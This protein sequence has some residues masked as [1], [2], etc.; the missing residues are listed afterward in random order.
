[1]SCFFT[2]ILSAFDQRDYAKI[3]KHIKINNV[4]QLAEFL[5]KHNVLTSDVIWN[6]EKLSD[7]LLSENKTAINEY[8]VQTIN[9]GYFCSACEPFLLL[10]CQLFKVDI[11]HEYCGYKIKYEIDDSGRKIN[12]QS[13][14]GHFWI[15]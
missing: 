12:F 13:N 1:M 6:G 5:K 9:D 3:D 11:V 14:S 2:G 15:G 7:K 10:I 4:R 8:N